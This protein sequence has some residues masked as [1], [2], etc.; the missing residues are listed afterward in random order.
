MNKN[1]ADIV[2][3]AILIA[4]W[5]LPLLIGAR[6]FRRKG[7]SPT[8]MWIGT[9]LCVVCAVFY[10]LLVHELKWLG[11]LPFVGLIALSVALILRPRPKALE[12]FSADKPAQAAAAYGR[13]Q[14][15]MRQLGNG[16]IVLG[17]SITVTSSYVCPCHSPA[18]CLRW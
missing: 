5:L 3:A 9:L 12:A 7:Y 1:I 2:I 8:W 16:L 10:A 6:V 15:G 11:I 14:T 13:Y 17:Y 4:V 18:P